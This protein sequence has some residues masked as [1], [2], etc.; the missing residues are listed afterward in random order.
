MTQQQLS[1]WAY[2]IYNILTF[3]GVSQFT[4]S[5]NKKARPIDPFCVKNLKS[6]K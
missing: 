5:T 2:I 4:M 6:E 3:E 1:W